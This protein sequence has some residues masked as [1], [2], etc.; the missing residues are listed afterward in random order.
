MLKEHHGVVVPDRCD[1][2][3]LEI[4]RGCRIGHLQPGDVGERGGE[5]LRMLSGRPDAAHGGPQHDGHPD[6]PAGHVGV[7][8]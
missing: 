1:Q 5:H 4:S 3:A 2:Q 8:R 6:S 7:L